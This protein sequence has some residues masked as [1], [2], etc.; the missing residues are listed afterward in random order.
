VAKYIHAINLTCEV[1]SPNSDI[2]TVDEC[3]GAL[4]HLWWR[5]DQDRTEAAEV[6][7]FAVAPTAYAIENDD[8]QLCGNTEDAGESEDDCYD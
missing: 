6:L 8:C 3:L 2:P 4:Y 1:E 5:L 7:L